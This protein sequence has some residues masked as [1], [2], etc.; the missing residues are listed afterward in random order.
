ME[1]YN[2]YYKLNTE[3]QYMSD[4]KIKNLLGENIK[5]D[6]T[7]IEIEG[8]KIF[9]KK[10][11]IAELFIQNKLTTK[12]LYNLPTYYHYRIGSAGICPWRELL[13]HIK[14]TNFVLS[15][16]IDNFPI[17]YHY[18]ILE[19]V[20]A[21]INVEMIKRIKERWNNNERILKYEEDMMKSNT[22]IFLFLEYVGDSLYKTLEDKKMSYESFWNQSQPIINFLNQNDILH[23]DA[24]S[25]NYVV[26]DK[27]KLF[28]TD[29]GLSIDKDFEL[30]NDEKLFFRNNSN[31][32]LFTTQNIFFESNSDNDRQKIFEKYGKITF[33]QKYDKLAEIK[34]L[35]DM[36]EYRYRKLLEYKNIIISYN[37]FISNL[38]ASSNKETRVFPNDIQQGGNKSSL[39]TRFIGDAMIHR[40]DD[41]V[42]IGGFYYKKYMKYD[43]KYNNN[44]IKL[45]N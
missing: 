24:H 33:Q 43:M 19:D 36:D 14:T 23:M 6:K 40:F 42:V 30:T 22:Y 38:I 12:N 28:L 35:I 27:G 11:S 10:I 34:E 39:Q 2:N 15:G 8:T 44:Y 26:D 17:L 32:D 31:F 18:R 7:V 3:L 37:T 1:R 9:V 41:S 20:P 25:G 16:K 45:F 21:G 4:E 29:F 13:L 5:K